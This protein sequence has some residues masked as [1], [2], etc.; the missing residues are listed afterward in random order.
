MLSEEGFSVWCMKPKDVCAASYEGYVP[1]MEVVGT[2]RIFQRFIESRNVGYIE[3][4]GDGDS[5]A[6]L[7]V[8]NT[9]CPD[10]V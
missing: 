7:T 10:M 4:F 2:K 9:F 6:Y 8:K 1:M 5:K 3:L